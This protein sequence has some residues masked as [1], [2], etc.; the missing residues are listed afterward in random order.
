MSYL[1]KMSLWMWI[2]GGRKRKH[3]DKDYGKVHVQRTC[4]AIETTRS[5]S[6]KMLENNLNEKDIKWHESYSLTSFFEEL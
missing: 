3:D 2:G 4:I 5:L 6:H 1:Y